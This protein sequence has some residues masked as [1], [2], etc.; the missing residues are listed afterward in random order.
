MKNSIK[1]EQ[2]N[3]L[4]DMYKIAHK[5]D[6]AWQDYYNYQSHLFGGP[7]NGCDDYRCIDPTDE[8][9]LTN[10]MKKAK[11]MEEYFQ[12]IFNISYK[13]YKEQNTLENMKKV[14]QDII[15]DLE[16][17][18]NIASNH[19]DKCG[20]NFNDDCRNCAGFNKREMLK[21]ELKQAKQTFMCENEIISATMARQFTDQAIKEDTEC[22]KPI[23]NKIRDFAAKK[24]YY[25]YISGTTPDYII[26]K[27]NDLGYKTKLQKGDPRD[28]REQDN[29]CI[30][31]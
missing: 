27:L 4:W 26:K 22:L 18:V 30:S 17:R 16:Y 1:K 2:Y 15:K 31:W 8:S 13:E 21:E 19:C 7:G 3:D 23:M 6:I 12:N 28:T 24:Q 11:N 5:I 20:G 29:Y 9:Y 14:G 10:L 25:C